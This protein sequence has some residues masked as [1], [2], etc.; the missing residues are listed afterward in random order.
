[1]VRRRRQMP[2]GLLRADQVNWEDVAQRL[3]AR[4]AAVQLER[5]R[6]HVVAREAYVRLL[7]ADSRLSLLRHRGMRPEDWGPAVGTLA[8]CD[9]VIGLARRTEEHLLAL[10]GELA[11]NRSRDE[12]IRAMLGEFPQQP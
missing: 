11:P 1:M 8:E 2:N 5:D 9:L 3:E 7:H 4:L 10:L 12:L 6:L